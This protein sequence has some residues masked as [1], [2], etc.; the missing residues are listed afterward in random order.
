[1]T[2]GDESNLPPNES[3]TPLAPASDANGTSGA[4]VESKP[5]PPQVDS[6]ESPEPKNL[7]AKATGFLG[8]VIE[9][10]SGDLPPCNCK[11]P[12]EPGQ[13]RATC[14][15]RKGNG[16]LDRR[17]IVPVVPAGGTT[18]KTAGTDVATPGALVPEKPDAAPKNHSFYRRAIATFARGRAEFKCWRIQNR[19]EPILGHDEAAKT[20]SGFGFRDTEIAELENAME[21]AA[22]F[23]D[24][25]EVSPLGNVLMILG[26]YEVHAFAQT[27]ALDRRLALIQAAIEE[28]NRNK[29]RAESKR[30]DVEQTHSEEVTDQEEESGA[31]SQP[32]VG[33]RRP[34]RK[35]A[36]LDDGPEK[37]T[38]E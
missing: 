24:W 9:R 3:K 6:A 14:P 36:A 10:A 37:E 18:E 20:A 27:K 30:E 25:P 7:F 8:R 2:A 13:H 34:N 16:G 12:G 22:K 26:N 21:E 38:G 15:R 19:I 17:F 11:Q 28:G 33:T 4:S 35:E 32:K 29:R 1:M 31:E 5:N 23:H